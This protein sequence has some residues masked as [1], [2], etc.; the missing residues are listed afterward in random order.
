MGM[1]ES[2]SLT[3]P[4]AKGRDPPPLASRAADEP[5]ASAASAYLPREPDAVWLG[6]LPAVGAATAASCTAA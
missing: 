4:G 1:Q 6:L 3:I 2:L 5:D